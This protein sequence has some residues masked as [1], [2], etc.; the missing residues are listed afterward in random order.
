MKD[1]ASHLCL[2]GT[3]LLGASLGMAARARGQAGRT[4][5]WTRS[6]AGRRACA[7]AEWCDAVADHPEEAVAGADRVILCVPVEQIPPLLARIHPHLGAHARVTDVGSTK[8][9]IEAA[10]GRIFSAGD[11]GTFLG[12][13]P[14]AGGERTGMAH[15]RADLFAGRTC[16]LTPPAHPVDEGIVAD[17]RAFWEGIG[18]RVYLLS[19]AE[20]DAWIARTSH[21]PHALASTLCA[22]LARK[23]SPRAVAERTGPGLLDT[24]RVAAGDP[25]L[26][27]GIFRDNR[28]AL[29]NALDDCREELAELRGLLA[30]DDPEGLRA[31]LQK[32]AD[33]RRALD[34]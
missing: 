21:L 6:A 7:E 11:H 13:H 26:W 8:Q 22:L 17:L 5:A 4:T 28:M 3:G 24:T 25:V 29:L 34:P 10:A 16:L 19:P 33:L 30:A 27:T 2:L 14:L 1:A 18:M 12:S 32:G 15:A 9:H 20:H 23:G 31:F